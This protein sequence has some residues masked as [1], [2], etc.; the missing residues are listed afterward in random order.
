M[1]ETLKRIEDFSKILAVEITEMMERLYGLHVTTEPRITLK[2]NGERQGISV[3]FED[4][5]VAPTIYTEGLF[6]QYQEGADIKN[7]AEKISQ[8]VYQ[9]HQ[10]EPQMPTLSPEAAKEHVRLALVNTERNAEMLK[11]TPHF[12]LGD[13]SAIPRWYISEEASFVVSTKLASQMEMTP[14]EVLKMAKENT[15]RQQYS[16]QKMSD[17]LKNLMV[18]DGM[19]PTMAESLTPDDNLPMYVI[20]C[21]SQLDG[22][23]CILNEAVLEEAREKIGTDSMIILPSSR[24]EVIVI[25]ETDDTDPIALAN[26]VREINGSTVSA[27][28]FLSDNILAWDGRKLRMLFQEP[29]MASPQVEMPKVSMK[30]RMG[31]F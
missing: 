24:H 28:D 21:S 30:M 29:E 3:H 19:D 1:E 13:I 12:E 18:Q 31:G 2:T 25:P 10:E 22:A 7:L 15:I 8:M 16:L 14:E 23:S 9:A 5:N 17:L 27:E 11:T 26:M 6:R 20:T 4:S